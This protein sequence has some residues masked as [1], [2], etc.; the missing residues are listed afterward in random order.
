MPPAAYNLRHDEGISIARPLDARDRPVP[1]KNTDERLKFEN[2]KHLL[3]AQRR[4]PPPWI[5]KPTE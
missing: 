2:S 1:H 5:V 3:M 4:F